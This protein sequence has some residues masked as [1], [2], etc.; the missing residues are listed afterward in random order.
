VG[1][2]VDESRGHELAGGVDP[3]DRPI[4]GDAR[5]DRRDL[6]ELD[7]D[8]PLPTQSLARVEHL[9]VGDHQLVFRRRIGRVEAPWRGKARRL[10]ETGRGLRRGGAGHRRT[11]RGGRGSQNAT[12]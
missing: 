5:C 12:P 9:A 1:V 2:Q 3:L 10:R 6:A 4:G 11:G 8:V 7:A